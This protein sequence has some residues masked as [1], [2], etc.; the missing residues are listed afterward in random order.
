MQKSS[1]KPCLTLLIVKN[2]ALFFLSD[3]TRKKSYRGEEIYVDRCKD[4]N[5]ADDNKTVDNIE[6]DSEAKVK[7]K[8][9]DSE[10][11]LTHK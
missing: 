10:N 1:E 5:T 7:N 2:G 11:L 3:Q 8:Q 4:G 9:R 6:T